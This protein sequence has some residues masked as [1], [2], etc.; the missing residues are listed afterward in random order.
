M[1]RCYVDRFG[2]HGSKM[3]IT[4]SHAILSLKHTETVIYVLKKKHNLFWNY[5]LDNFFIC[6]SFRIKR[7]HF[8]LI[9]IYRSLFVPGKSCFAVWTGVSEPVP[10]SPPKMWKSKLHFFWGRVYMP[11]LAHSWE[12]KDI[13]VSSGNFSTVHRSSYNG[14]TVSVSQLFWNSLYYTREWLN[15]YIEP[16]PFPWEKTVPYNILIRIPA[17]DELYAW[18]V[19]LIDILRF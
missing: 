13:S 14:N 6:M 18:H 16:S 17:I 7:Q 19:T 3:Q 2:Y 5:N 12:H 11:S 9:S 15:K 8:R 10:W 4:C 1:S